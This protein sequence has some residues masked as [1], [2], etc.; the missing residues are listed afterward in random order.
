MSS[1]SR[2]R[3]LTINRQRTVKAVVLLVWLILAARLVHVQ[4]VQGDRFRA[5]ARRQ[6]TWVEPIP[7]RPGDLLD[8]RGRLLATTVRVQSLY[9]NPSL[10]EE[11]EHFVESLHPAIAI[12]SADLLERITRDPS[13]EFLWVQRRLSD[14]E[15]DAVRALDLPAGTWGLRPE[16]HRRYPQGTLAAHVIG[17]RDI[18]GV[19]RGGAEEAFDS[20]IRGQDGRRRLVRDARGY[21]IEVLEEVTQPPRHGASVVLTIDSVVQL[22][23]ERQL[24][25]LMQEWKPRGACAIV[26]DPQSG[27]VLAMASR[28]TFD[29][30]APGGADPEAWSNRALSA[31]FEPGSTIKPCIV[32]WAVDRGI[33][34]PGEEFDCA[35]GAYRMG[36]RT[37]HDHHP[38]GVLS[39]SDILVKSSN[40][41]MAR[42]GERMSNQRLYAAVTD[43][44]FG[45]KTGIDIPGE[46]SGMVHPLDEWT[47]YSTG[48]IPMGQELTATPLQVITAHSVL[49]NG[50]QSVTPHVLSGIAGRT[51]RISRTRG[52]PI[53]NEENAHWIVQGPLTGVVERGTGTQARV[54]GLS[55]FG[56]SGTA[57]KVDPATG[58]YAADRHVCSFVC[59]AP[60]GNPELLVLVSVDE[61]TAD[62]S[63][64]GGTVAAPA[65]A[66]ILR[67]SLSH[68]GA[69]D[70]IATGD[71]HTDEWK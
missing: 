24:D 4:L 11:P 15:A 40:I 28:P 69:S 8:R 53:V 65:A 31:V 34:D 27:D 68:L 55:V 14:T 44:G 60:A 16:F 17:L 29:P 66:V 7:A 50:G 3:S 9:V 30:N 71:S 35:R 52:A 58:R 70:R 63:H 2:T 61:P 43:F 46:L 57:Q 42:I 49:A 25:W 64:F 37:L 56:K 47:S 12:D 1:W 33:I 39:V 19:G 32:A 5:Q 23:A 67:Q 6:Q 13:R 51:T 54:E 36:G 62:G 45:Q 48:S 59:G 10:I 20:L 18:D 26:L 41:G 38:Y 21:V 22:I